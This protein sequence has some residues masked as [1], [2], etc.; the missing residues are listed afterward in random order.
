MFTKYRTECFAV[1]TTGDD[2]IFPYE[3]IIFEY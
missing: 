3:I 1:K 2:K